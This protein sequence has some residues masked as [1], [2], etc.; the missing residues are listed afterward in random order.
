MKGIRLKIVVSII[1]CSLLATLT[2]G[3]FSI[4]YIK[5]LIRQ[6]TYD[7]LTESARVKGQAMNA[8]IVGMEATVDSLSRTVVGTLDQKK[9]A[10]PAYYHGYSEQLE[11]IAAQFDRNAI[12]AMSV[13]VRF[14]PRISYS[15]SGFFHADANGDGILE[16]QPPTDLAQYAPSDVEH[17]GWFYE[18]LK[19]GKP[20]WMN[21]YHNA[22]I[23]IDM[24]SHIAPIVTDGKAIGV[25]GIDINFAQLRNIVTGETKIG[26]AFLLNQDYHFLVHETYRSTDSLSTVENGQLKPVEAAMMKAPD[27]TVEFTLNGEG[28]VVGFST[29]KN[30]WIV[31][32]V[33]TRQEAFSGLSNTLAMLL[34]MNLG[35]VAGM[36]AVSVL[37]GKRLNTVIL[38][39]SELENTVQERTQQLVQTNEYLENSMAELETHQAE[40]TLVNGRLEESLAQLKETQEQLIISEKLASLGEL[41]AGVAHEINTP[42][43][44]GVT[45]NTYIEQQLH[46]A[47]NRFETGTLTREDLEETLVSSLES[48]AV[49]VRN[50]NR[51]ADIVTNFKQVAVD[52]SAL[53]LRKIN[54]HEYIN[55]IVMSLAPKL[56]DTLHQIHVDCDE[57]LELVLYPGV[58]AQI[59]T[60]LI[61]NSLIHG[62]KDTD[63]GT[64]HIRAAYRKPFIDLVY[65]DNGVGIPPECLDKVF[66]PFFTTKRHTGCSGL[67]LHI[68]H[69]LVTQ[70]LKGTL[71]LRSAPG[72]GVEFRISFPETAEAEHR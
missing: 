57:S 10:D 68:V 37:V 61:T 66:N 49:A 63:A 16:R 56:K 33:M 30:G 47:K 11:K 3:G 9:A 15:T 6:N 29:L 21:P 14:D 22:N 58:L 4:V 59:L 38:R 35:V 7:Y 44:V 50:L 32:V 40:L 43:G 12:N 25:V 13:Y 5:E 41:V 67:G 71:R 45:L 62:F 65:S 1:L 28:K 39:N 18:P 64:I 53:D 54:L 60:N 2:A 34:I 42:L 8:V 36:V 20:I 70:N 26:K 31:G 51:A 27:G 52:Q 55:M 46:D 23:N 69:N 72:E 19:A 48:A 24:L 17:V